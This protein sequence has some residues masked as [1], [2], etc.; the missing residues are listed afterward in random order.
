MFGLPGQTVEQFRETLEKAV[1]LPIEHVSAYSLKVEEK[2]VFYQL[3]RKGKLPLPGED[4]EAEMYE[5]LRKYMKD[6]GFNHYEISNFAKP[7][8]ESSHNLTYWKNED[9]YGIG[10]GAH[11][12][13]AGTRRIN[14]GPLPKYMNAVKDTGFPYREE[15]EVTFKE[16]MEEEMF[17]GLRKLSGVSKQMFKDKYGREITD[18]FPLAVNLAEKGL[19]EEDGEN[20]RLTEK[21]LLLGNEVFEGFLLSDD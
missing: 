13:T 20:F 1:R 11:G 5:E 14:H 7:G 2:T 16:K 12:Y 3:W 9:Y 17:M 6:A 18:V 21:G 15:H 10:A 4:T 19:L 8:F